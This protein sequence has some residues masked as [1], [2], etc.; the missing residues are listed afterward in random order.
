VK[1]SQQTKHVEVRSKFVTEMTIEGI[2]KVIFVRSED[3]DTEIFKKNLPKDIHQE[4]ARKMIE[5][6]G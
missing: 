6:K 3:N 5:S 4:H 1:I 2:L